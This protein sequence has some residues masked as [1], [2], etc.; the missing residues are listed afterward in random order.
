MREPS[1]RAC[2]EKCSQFGSK[3]HLQPFIAKFELFLRYHP[4]KGGQTFNITPNFMPLSLEC[5]SNSMVEVH[6][7]KAFVPIISFRHGCFLAQVKL[8]DIKISTRKPTVR[9][10]STLFFMG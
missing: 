4:F 10:K 6:H 8:P 2:F 1:I 7:L 3:T 5:L 9:Y